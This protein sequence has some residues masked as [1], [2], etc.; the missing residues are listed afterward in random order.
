MSAYTV[1]LRRSARIAAKNLAREDRTHYEI[2]DNTLAFKDIQRRKLF[3]A[4]K[5]IVASMEKLETL[6]D[7]VTTLDKNTMIAYTELYSRLNLRSVQYF[8][9]THDLILG[10]TDEKQLSCD[11]PSVVFMRDLSK[12]ANDFVLHLEYE[13]LHSTNDYLL[14]QIYP[15]FCKRMIAQIEKH[16]Q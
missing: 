7:N 15:L 1:P 13:I 3:D 5:V 11:I 14:K 6:L 9:Q 2:Q 4:W 8:E 12:R 10:L 16:L